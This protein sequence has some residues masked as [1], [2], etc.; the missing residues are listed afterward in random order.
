MFIKVNLQ[1]FAEETNVDQEGVVDRPDFND[2]EFNDNESTHQES[3][4]EDVNINNFADDEDETQ[5]DGVGE[6]ESE[7]GDRDLPE[8][9]KKQSPEENKV[10]K[11]M[12]LKAEKEAREKIEAEL[13]EQKKVIEAQKMAL[14][15]ELAE[16]RIIDE[17][18]NPKKVYDYAY[19]NNI[20][21]EVAEKMLRYEAQQMIDAEK[22]KVTEKFT[23]LQTTKNELRKDKYFNLLEKDVDEII[24]SNPGVDYK[25]VY[26]YQRGLKA[27]EL[28]SKLA[29]NVE[30]RTIANMQDRN[31]RK[32]L[33]QS[34]SGSDDSLTPSAVLDR[35]AM[36]M[37]IA[38]GND[39]RE[40]ASY[41]R[42]NSKKRG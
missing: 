14:E 12:R 13:A 18:L 29:K 5:D 36:D 16:K 1:L 7:E 34:A 19:E 11:N 26:Y 23:Q 9:S 42:K 21:E 24:Q 4:W 28:E 17:Q 25:A 41:V 32:T 10:Y 3:D 39:P 20:S 37:S 2:A 30:Q 31:R 40:I 33:G 15:Q 6:T 27:D 8:D 35:A 22:K 38:F